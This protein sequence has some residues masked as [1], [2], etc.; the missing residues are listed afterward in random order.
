VAISVEARYPVASRRT[1][2]SVT[3]EKPGDTGTEGEVMLE[4]SASSSRRCFLQGAGW[5]RTWWIS[6]VG[7]AGIRAVA[8]SLQC[9]SRGL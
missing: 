4:F 8:R 7:G 5:M 3:E 2:A 6:E 9:R 1:R